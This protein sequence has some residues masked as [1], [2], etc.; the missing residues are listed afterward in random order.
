MTSDVLGSSNAGTNRM[1]LSPG[2]T[3]QS[4][5]LLGWQGTPPTRAN[6]YRMPGQKAGE[7]D[8]K[9]VP[10]GLPKKH[11]IPLPGHYDSAL[12]DAPAGSGKKEIVTAPTNP[13]FS[14]YITVFIAS[15]ISSHL[16]QYLGTPKLAHRSNKPCFACVRPSARLP[17]RLPHQNPRHHGTYQ[18]ESSLSTCVAF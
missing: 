14:T 10:C 12:P 17:A 5:S 2:A 8:H 11:V 18:P 15:E 6:Q 16:S 7:R 1:V 13:Q 9:K 4:P 3:R